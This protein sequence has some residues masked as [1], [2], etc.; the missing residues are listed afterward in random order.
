[1]S[2][3]SSTK[4]KIIDFIRQNGQVPTKEIIDFLNISKQATARHL[5]ELQALNLIQKTGRT[6]KV[7]YSITSKISSKIPVLKEKVSD[8]AYQLIEQNFEIIT[9]EGK[10]ERG[11]E[12]FISWA[13]TRGFEVFQCS[14]KYQQTSQK[15]NF[16]KN[17][18]G[19]IDATKKAKTTFKKDIYLDQLL[20]SEFSAWEIFGKTPF[21]QSLL[22]AKQSENKNLIKS[23]VNKTKEQLL[24]LIISQNIQAVGY[25]SPTVRRRV[26]FMK[27]LEKNYNFPLPLIQIEKLQNDILVPQ[28][29]LKNP[30]D[31]I[32]NA[33]QTF[34]IR[35]TT[36]AQNILLIDD[37]VG[38]GSSLNFVAQKI[39]QKNPTVKKIIGY[40]L[41]GT[42]NGVIN[43]SQKFEV[44]VEA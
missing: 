34:A 9:P 2:D 10:I 20:Y 12:A 31:R 36:L 28:K 39:K 22:Y 41:C 25:V 18:F 40:A 30:L 13:K 11:F 19:F 14:Q 44:V 42:P 16:Y 8:T 5:A 3:I 1:M 33:V 29:T 37:F 7:Y 6:P 17:K 26:Q 32:Q 21:Y 24:N 35:G 15:Y 43:D 23:L 38:S 27:E 4:V